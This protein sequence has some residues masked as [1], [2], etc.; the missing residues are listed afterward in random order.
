MSRVP[1]AYSPELIGEGVQ[2]TAVVAFARL[3]GSISEGNHG[4]SGAR[5]TGIRLDNPRGLIFSEGRSLPISAVLCCVIKENTR[6]TR[7]IAREFIPHFP[8]FASRIESPPP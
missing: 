3:D 2:P 6:I 4:K 8:A 1:A 7:A 5:S